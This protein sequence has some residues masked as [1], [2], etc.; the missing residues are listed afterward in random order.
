[1]AVNA[2]AIHGTRPWK[3]F[4]E[5]PGIQKSQAGAGMNGTAEHFN[6]KNRKDLTGE[7]IRFTTKGKTLYLYAAGILNITSTHSKLTY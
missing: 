4:G 2:E 6:E 7:D 1:M 5:G 3:V